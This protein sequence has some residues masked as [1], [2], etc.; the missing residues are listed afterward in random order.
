[1]PTGILRFSSALDLARQPLRQR[2]AAPADA[3]EGELVQVFVFSRIFVGQADQRPVDLRRAHQLG[4]FAGE[5][6]RS[7]GD[8]LII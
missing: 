4:F 3:D 5:D 6:I 8:R 2:H 7:V 1:M